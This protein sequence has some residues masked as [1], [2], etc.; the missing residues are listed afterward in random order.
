MWKPFSK[1]IRNSSENEFI[2][3]SNQERNE[4]YLCFSNQESFIFS[5]LDKSSLQTIKDNI[6]QKEMLEEKSSFTE[7]NENKKLEKK[8]EVELG[9][10]FRKIYENEFKPKYFAKQN[11]NFYYPLRGF[12][13][14]FEE[15]PELHI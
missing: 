2:V 10:D 12:Y 8:D 6:L 11:Y 4:K 9:D 1:E 14:N 7:D 15:I 13:S 3:D 5:N